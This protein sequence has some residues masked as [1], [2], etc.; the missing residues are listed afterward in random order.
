[1]RDTFINPFS[2][3][4]LLSISNGMVASSDVE[5]DLMNAKE[6]GR[7]AMEKFFQERLSDTAKY[8][9]YDKMTKT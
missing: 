6:K 4:P 7:V 8:S 3:N 1:M 2:D 9:L 5:A